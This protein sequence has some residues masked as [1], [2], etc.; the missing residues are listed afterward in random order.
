MDLILTHDNA[1]FDAVASQLAACKLMP[2]A[3]PVLPNRCNRNVRHFTALYWDELPFLQAKELRKEAVDAIVLVDTQT[4]QTP[5][6]MHPGTAIQIIDHHALHEGLPEDWQAAIEPVGAA[7]TILVERIRSRQLPLT[8]VETTLLLLGVYEDTG[9]LTYGTTTARDA[10]AAAWLLEQG[11]L[12]DVVRDF[13]QHPLSDDQIAVF[14]RL[15]EA[16]ATYDIE[17]HPVVIATADA[18]DLTEEIATLAHKLRDLLDPAAVFLLVNLGQHVQLVARSSVDAIDVGQVAEHFG[19]GGH[20]RASA[21]IIREM[22][23]KQAEQALLAYLRR[24]VK[25]S[26]TVA[27][28]MSRGVQILPP[29]ARAD[30]ADR[31]MRR[32]G[33]EGFPIVGGGRVIGL[34]TRRAVDRAMAHGLEGVRVEQIMDA[35]QVGVHPEDSIATLQQTMMLSGWGQIPVLDEAGKISGVV[36]RTDLIKHMGHSSPAATRRGE[37]TDLLE[38]ALPPLLMALVREVGRVADEMGSNAYIVGGFVRDLLLRQ[39]TADVDFVVE[40]NAIALTRAL[41]Q[42]F[43]G[44]TRSHSRFGTG[45][46]L[47][48][49]AVWKRIAAELDVAIGKGDRLPPHIDFAS[50]RTEF[51]EAPTVLPEVE[52]S[53]IKL[54]V[55]RRDF[56]INT[57]AIRLGPQHFGQLLDFYGG[58]SDLDEGVIRVLHSFSFIDDPTRILRAARFEQRLGFRIE[59][60]TAELIQHALPMLERVTGDRLKHEVESIFEERQPERVLCR[61]DDLGVLERLVPGLTCDAWL[62]CTYRALRSALAA[63]LWPELT[64]EFD[65]AVPYFALLTY[66]LGLDEA[67]AAGKRLN[68]R[69]RTADVLDAVA[70]RRGVLADLAQPLRPS[71]VDRRLHRAPDEVLVT[72]WA[73]APT[74]TARRQIVAYATRLR[75]VKPVADGQALK[76][77]GVAPGPVYGE[78]LNGL[79]EAWL[80]GK[81]SSAEEEATLLDRLLA[82]VTA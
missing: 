20:G 28:L 51:Y 29:D 9:S 24:T 43:G 45:K 63:P 50:A 67:Q 10:Y 39:P 79:R 14:E 31:E 40:G 6:G 18:P 35:G 72:L 13:L 71:E 23:P 52:R 21:A 60:R 30:R 74:A 25:P 38:A 48:T 26:L 66:R 59:P 27:D 81:I 2:G 17:G 8:P 56:T 58:E 32:Y 80:D 19:G 47:L 7:V 57:L 36:T 61:L 44:D 69:R 37:T 53:S 34:L 49:R 68:V 64:E 82:E 62:T 76:A 22:T 4:L 73:A 55:H 78:L 5:R 46:W 16:A 42:R 33:Y 1:D 75:H 11:A 54:D 3:L 65:P 70:A 77:R 15:E 12:L 41:R